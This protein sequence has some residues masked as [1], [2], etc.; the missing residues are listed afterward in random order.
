MI[1]SGGSRSNWRYFAKHLMKTE[2][3]ERVHVAEIRGLVAENVLDAFREMD[4]IAM[5]T[6][7][8]NFF[9]HAD[10]N[11]R[12]GEEL[13]AEQWEA[14]ADTLEKN[15]GLAGQ[16]RFV[17][18]HEKEGRTH[19]HVVWLRVD[20]DTLK[21]IPDSWD[22]T[23]HQKTSR[24]LE[25]TFG[26]EP[27]NG[28]LGPDGKRVKRRPK[29]QE[30]M[31]GDRSGIDPNDVTRQVT[32][33]WRQADT[34]QAFAAALEERGY[35][36][37]KG[38]KRDFVIIDQ[39]GHDHSLA[40]R[41]EGAKAADVRARMADVDRD[42]LPS[43]ADAR[44]MVRRGLA[45]EAGP[46]P[47]ADIGGR[48]AGPPGQAKP[49]HEAVPG[50]HSSPAAAR[51]PKEATA[52]VEHAPKPEPSVFDRLVRRLTEAVRALE[53]GP[54][55]AESVESHGHPSSPGLPSAPS[56]ALEPGA[57]ERAVKDLLT[58]AKKAA[59]VIAEAAAV[60]IAAKEHGVPEA[61]R[62]L[63]EFER[64]GGALKRARRDGAPSLPATMKRLEDRLGR[65]RT[66]HSNA[67]TE[68]RRVAETSKR[69]I[70]ENGGEPV[71]PGGMTFWQRTGAVLSAARE[72][73]ESWTRDVFTSSVERVRRSRPAPQQDQ[74]R[75][76]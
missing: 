74:E 40:R 55:A 31:R 4:A 3:N 47:R 71:M 57:F 72:R 46:Q 24:T 22:Y 37:A 44:A 42:T 51:D 61:V 62:D 67:G 45:K 6:R 13:T 15:L 7:V 10:I 9:Y 59:P 1:I 20:L 11:P 50:E 21:A 38:D 23:Q 66:A 36:L 30:V 69:A 29:N 17:V 64:I 49:G 43:V 2:E 26:L 68:F 41:V 28:V 18:E 76:R 73:A 53:G 5:G 58:E 75:E 14:A 70:R 8:T 39:A 54:T 19:R 63:T 27:V 25:E 65:E 33:L 16:P 48:V 34:G 35:V 32:A 60:A 52:A 12:E 56:G